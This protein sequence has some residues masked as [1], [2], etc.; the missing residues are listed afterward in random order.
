[1][2]FNLDT[3]DRDLYTDSHF[4]HEALYCFQIFF[5]ILTFILTVLC[6]ICSYKAIDKYVEK[7]ANDRNS[8]A[9]ATAHA[10][11]SLTFMAI[12]FVLDMIALSVRDQTPGYYTTSYNDTLFRFPELVILP[13]LFAVL[14]FT[15][16]TSLMGY[17]MKHKAQRI[18]PV[19]DSGWSYSST[20]S[21]FTCQLHSYCLAN[22]HSVCC[23]HW[24]R[25]WDLVHLSSTCVQ[26][27]LQRS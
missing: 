2:A 3:L 14:L 18:F 11:I 27:N 15:M 19:P 1:M 17:Y 7:H 6:G 20:L 26:T 8:W 16:F 13:D 4:S 5:P 21:G 9:A 24:T 10:V 25:L 23:W 12:V 22:R